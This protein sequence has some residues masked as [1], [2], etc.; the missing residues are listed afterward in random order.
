M[1]LGVFRYLLH[2]AG[3]RVT[4]TDEIV[5]YG[6]NKEQYSNDGFVGLPNDVLSDEYYVVTW[7]PPYRQ[8]Q[9]LVV[10][11]EDSTSVSI[12]MGQY[13]GSRYVDYNRKRYYKGNTVKENLNKYDTWQL[14]T[15][16]DLSGSFVTANKKISVFSGN[17]K[18]KI[19]RGSSQDHL[20]EHLTPVNTWGKKFATVPIPKRTCGDYFKFI[21]SEDNTRVT[22]S[23][24]YSSSF[25]I[26][27]KGGVV[28]KVI[29]SKAYCRVVADKPIMLVQFVQSQISSSEPSDPAMMIIPPCEQ[30]GADYTFAT[31]K[32]SQGS[33]ENYFMFIVEEKQASGLRIDGKSFPVNT[34]F[35]RISGT[36]LVGGY[37]SI[38]EGTHT[39]R[40]TSP[41]AIFGGFLYGKAPYETYGF[42][43]GMRMAKVNAVSNVFVL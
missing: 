7:Y 9:L 12:T 20:V 37:I 23:G 39:V 36:T 34:R 21:A 40:H 25:T 32:Y 43:T 10:G 2:F 4:A 14:V 15:S 30:Y 38:S 24:G 35:Q 42:T 26:S 6:I 19:G 22:I 1:K 33:Y 28:Q 41:I 31:P 16:G 5:I 13:M 11:V 27:K 29:S 18:T 17:K 8:C 3:I